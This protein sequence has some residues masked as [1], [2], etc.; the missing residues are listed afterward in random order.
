MRY[1]QTTPTRSPRPLS[2]D[3]FA[4][5]EAKLGLKV[6]WVDDARRAET[7]HVVDAVGLCRE[8]PGTEPYRFEQELKERKAWCSENASAGWEIE[9]LGEPG[10]CTGRRFRFARLA[11]AVMFKLRFGTVL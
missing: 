1:R 11:D 7:P 2:P 4:R 9:P 8:H 6:G 10:R 3:F 5:L